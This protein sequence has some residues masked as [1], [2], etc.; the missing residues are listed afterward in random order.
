[1]LAMLRRHGCARACVDGVDWMVGLDGPPADRRGPKGARGRGAA[2]E[3]DV[4][5]AREQ[6]H[7]TG[8]I[9]GYDP[10]RNTVKAAFGA[11]GS[12]RVRGV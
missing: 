6:P 9:G 11:D 5:R 1:M 7:S 3:A 12:T 10:A 8:G 4:H 2:R